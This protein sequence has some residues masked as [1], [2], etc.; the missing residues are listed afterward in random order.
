MIHCHLALMLKLKP[1]IYKVYLLAL[2]T[3]ACGENDACDLFPLM[4]VAL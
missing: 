2:M 1:D 3:R 4:P